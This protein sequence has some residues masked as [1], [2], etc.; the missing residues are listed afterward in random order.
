M[1]FRRLKYLGCIC[2][3]GMM[4]VSC[5][6]NAKQAKDELN[7]AKNDIKN[8]QEL[9]KESEAM[10]DNINTLKEESHLTEE[11]FK[12]WSPDTLLGMPLTSSTINMIPGLG[13]CGNTY[14]IK[15]KRIR[16][17]V[18]DGA[19]EKGAGSVSPYRMSSKMDYNE[20]NTWGYTKSKIING[21]KVK[22]SYLKGNEKYSLSMFYD[23]R[24]AVDIETQEVS[25][26]D[27][28]R[29]LEELNLEELKNL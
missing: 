3:L 5:G 19:G 15:N 4:L 21:I 14:S 10:V 28:P 13:S 24:F 1:I 20:E 25:K 2:I 12:T 17:M 7:K 16:V 22:E 27:L 11:E 18:I 26:E 9:A 29:I 23:E 6:D 8:A